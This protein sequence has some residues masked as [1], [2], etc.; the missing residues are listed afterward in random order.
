M[1]KVKKTT[2]E[3][4]G[5]FLQR[6]INIEMEFKKHRLIM[7]AKKKDLWQGAKINIP[8]IGNLSR[9]TYTNLKG[10]KVT[11]GTLTLSKLMKLYN[12]T[13]NIK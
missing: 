9:T 2:I 10:K 12:D 3:P 6:L 13:K 8:D 1:K 5:K 11:G 4:I 7:L